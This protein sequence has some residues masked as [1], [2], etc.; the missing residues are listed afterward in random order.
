MH[1]QHQ[2]IIEFIYL[3][4]IHACSVIQSRPTFCGP[5][6]CSPP[7]FSVHGI[8]SARILER[9]PF[10]PP[11]DLPDLGLEPESPALVGGFFTLSH[12]GVAYLTYQKTK[13]CLCFLIVVAVQLLSMLD[14]LW[15]HGLQH[16]RLPYPSLSPAQIC[17]HW[18]TDAN[19]PSHSPALNLSQHQ[20]LFQWVSS[21]HQMAKVLV[22]SI[23]PFNKYSGL[24]S[25]RIDWFD[26]PA[27]QGTLKSLLWH[28]SLKASILWRSAFF[29]VQVSHP[30]M[31]TEKN[32]SFDYMDLC[33]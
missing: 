26:L 16:S 33:Q 25:F 9:L 14:S 22:F 11:G 23:S 8:F 20:G 30:Y 12:L 4:C 32:H 15:P 21:S 31:T 10:P 6:D 19:Q 29:M 24:I 18:V 5:T 7:S 28:H 1:D 13:D 3:T 27:V 2:E 17:V